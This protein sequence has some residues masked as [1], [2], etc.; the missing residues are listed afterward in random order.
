MI[1]F[2]IWDELIYHIFDK[3]YLPNTTKVKIYL[4]VII[5]DYSI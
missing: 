1:N 4:V 2:K 5:G 3:F